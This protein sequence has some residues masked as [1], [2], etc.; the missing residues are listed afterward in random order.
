MRW[1]SAL[2]GGAG[3]TG[4]S[5]SECLVRLQVYEAWQ[6]E[7]EVRRERRAVIVFEHYPVEQ[8]T[9]GVV[10][11]V[12]AKPTDQFEAMAS[13]D[14][15]NYHNRRFEGMLNVP[16][17]GDKLDLR[18]AG[19]WTKRNG[20]TFNEEND[21]SVDG[22][23][24]WSGRVSLLVHPIEKLTANFVWEHFSEDDDRL[25]SGKQLCTLDN[26]P[27]FVD[28]RAG[29]QYPNLDDPNN[30]GNYGAWLTQGCKPG[31]LYGPTAFQTPN[32]GALP[33]IAEWEYVASV[34]YIA[35]GVEPYGSVVQSQNLR[36]ISS[37]LDPKY[38]AKNDTF[39]INA[40][41]NITNALTLTSQTGYNKD[42]LYSTEDYNRFNTAPNLFTDAT[43][44][45]GGAL[46]GHQ[47]LSIK[48][49]CSV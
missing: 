27:A 24:L 48:P 49:A 26:G 29:R 17:V 21:K 2:I 22:R 43:D 41:Y 6:P 3:K 46:L 38:R 40:D 1:D 39:E 10:N 31:P 4:P 16:I 37:E 44:Q 9:A 28:G 5:V 20:Y 14:I 15:G 33:F 34:H 12:S 13:A 35:P 7:P 45:N 47:K 36:T 18:V 8:P 42:S 23:D 19:E 11:L 30:G 25:R 32:A